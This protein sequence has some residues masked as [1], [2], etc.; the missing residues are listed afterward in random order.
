MYGL[1][2]G[3]IKPILTLFLYSMRNIFPICFRVRCVLSVALC[4]YAELH[5]GALL[6]HCGDSVE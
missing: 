6:M 3:S 4:G 1:M 5:G 2:I